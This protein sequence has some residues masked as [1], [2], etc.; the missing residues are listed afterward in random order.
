[1]KF[2]NDIIEV[3]LSIANV[4]ITMIIIVILQQ[5]E[6]L[7]GFIEAPTQRNVV[8]TA[9]LVTNHNPTFLNLLFVASEAKV[10]YKKAFFRVTC[11]ICDKFH[12]FLWQPARPGQVQWQ[13][14]HQFT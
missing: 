9:T 10:V 14:F 6:I 13:S 5:D 2:G 4:V 12:H 1:M 7:C 3:F 8:D 11:T